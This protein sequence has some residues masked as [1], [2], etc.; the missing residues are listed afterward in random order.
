MSRLAL[1]GDQALACDKIRRAFTSSDVK[2]GEP[3]Y[4]LKIIA[5]HVIY[6]RGRRR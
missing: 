3:F 2:R 6:Q 5:P 1:L 4:D